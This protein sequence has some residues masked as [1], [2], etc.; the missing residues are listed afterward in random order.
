MYEDWAMKNF[1]FF[2]L[3][4]KSKKFLLFFGKVYSVKHTLDTTKKKLG[5]E[6]C[7]YTRTL[8]RTEMLCI[9]ENVYGYGRTQRHDIFLIYILP[10]HI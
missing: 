6:N 9:N 3:K 5:M 8:I 2:F 7:L 4:Q 10:K 1:F